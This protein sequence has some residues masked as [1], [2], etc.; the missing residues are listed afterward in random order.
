[1]Q[2]TLSLTLVLGEGGWLTPRP[3]CFTLGNDLSP[4][5]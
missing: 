3:S 1:V 2:L 4:I 5:V